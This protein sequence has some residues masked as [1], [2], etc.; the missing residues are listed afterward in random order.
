MWFTN[1]LISV[2][3]QVIVVI[4]HTK[5]ISAVYQ[6][7]LKHT[8]NL[9]FFLIVEM[10]LCW[11]SYPGGGWYVWAICLKEWTNI[12]LTGLVDLPRP[13]PTEGKKT[14]TV[15]KNVLMTCIWNIFSHSSFRFRK[16][17]TGCSA[18]WLLA[19]KLMAPSPL[20][21]P[22][23]FWSPDCVICR[24]ALPV[25]CLLVSYFIF[26]PPSLV[27]AHSS[28]MISPVGHSQ[29]CFSLTLYSWFSSFTPPLL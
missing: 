16:R 9:K 17:E 24:L 15:E 6:I 22:Y 21:S 3:S 12:T 8:A 7:T 28:P 19:V 1:L 10:S 27:P 13:C 29:S 4:C 20:S 23:R 5:L 2:E 18:H 14:L 11:I 26:G 25:A